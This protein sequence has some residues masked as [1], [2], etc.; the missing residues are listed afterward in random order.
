[1]HASLLFVQYCTLSTPGEYYVCIPLGI[2]LVKIVMYTSKPHD[3]IVCL[4]I[5]FMCCISAEIS[6]SQHSSLKVLESSVTFSS[7]TVRWISLLSESQSPGSGFE[8]DD[9][10]LTTPTNTATYT[11]SY[12]TPDN[13]SAVSTV[14]VLGRTAEIHSSL[15]TNL[16]PR[17]HYFYFITESSDI[18]V[19]GSKVDTFTTLDYRKL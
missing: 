3:S 6:A 1:M 7:A 15:L 10:D 14:S 13:V 16:K 12:Y 17:T 11:I 18:G 4:L 8:T 5:M 19:V 9:S 2:S